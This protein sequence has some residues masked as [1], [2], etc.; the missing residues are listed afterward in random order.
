MIGKRIQTR[1]IFHVWMLFD[2]N[3]KE[4]YF[5]SDLIIIVILL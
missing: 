4:D 5:S 2:N 1:T 3:K